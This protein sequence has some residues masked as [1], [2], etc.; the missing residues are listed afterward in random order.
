MTT[1]TTETLL[2]TIDRHGLAECVDEARLAQL[3]GYSDKQVENACQN[4][5]R[6]GFIERTGAG[7][8]RLTT[9]G[10]EAL[11]AGYGLRSGPR[12]PQKKGHRRLARGLRQRVW[13]C[14]RTGK[15]LTIDDV[16][17]RVIDGH[18][19]DPRSNIGKYLAGLKLAGYVMPVRR[20]AP[21]TPT[22]NGARRWV[23]VNDSGPLAPVV[24]VGRQAVYDPNTEQETPFAGGEA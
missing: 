14:L 21:L 10:S 12:G 23:L 8:H 9:A 2:K 4:L 11:A 7:C 24:R 16:V 19:R 17:L 6:H 13:N 15:K 5:R 20:E 1:W 3:T 18:E 22:S